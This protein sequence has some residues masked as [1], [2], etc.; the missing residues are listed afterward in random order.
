MP[1]PPT[2]QVTNAYAV[3]GVPP[4]ADAATIRLAYRKLALA[5]HPDKGGGEADAA[6]FARAATAHATLSDPARRAAHDAALRVGIGGGVDPDALSGI[7]VDPSSLS[8]VDAACLSLFAR[9]GVR[10]AHAPPPAALEAARTG[11]VTATKLPWSLGRGAALG[12]DGAA[13]PLS[14]TVD[15]GAAT[16]YEVPPPPA[17]ATAACFAA[18]SRGGSRVQLL[19]FERAATGGWDLVA[20]AD[21]TPTTGGGQLAALFPGLPF[22]T[23]RLDP[24]TSSAAAVAALGGDGA[25]ARVLRSLDGL[26]TRESLPAVTGPSLLAVVG[27]NMWRR[28]AFSVRAVAVMDKPPPTAAASNDP[29]CSMPDPLAKLRATEDAL[30]AKRSGLAALEAAHRAAEAALKKAADDIAAAGG[31]VDALR[32]AR[33]VAYL[34]LL[35]LLPGVADADKK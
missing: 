7:T 20:A 14:G 26:T 4:D 10:V 24:P 29:I 9:L 3:L 18:H 27:G 34:D 31:E 33:D 17:G 6:A 2:P 15:R 5:H 22:D 19:L 28:A 12:E 1:P 23:L 35:G 11:S 13:P 32:A 16:W 21:S 30:L 25:A 8:V